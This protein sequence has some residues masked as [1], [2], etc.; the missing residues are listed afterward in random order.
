M[1]GKEKAGVEATVQTSGPRTQIERTKEAREKLI[2]AAFVCFGRSGYTTTTLSDI[3]AEA[4]VSRE[5][6]RYH[7]GSRD[8]LAVVLHERVA[9]YWLTKFSAT[10]DAPMSLP[11]ALQRIG[12]M[13]RE[14]FVF[15]RGGASL[16]V[17]SAKPENAQL[18]DALMRANT[19]IFD[20]MS[21]I[22]EVELAA[23]GRAGLDGGA[24]TTIIF[25]TFRGLILRTS[26]DMPGNDMLKA[27]AAFEDIILTTIRR[28]K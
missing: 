14:D 18:R 27:W 21:E 20:R 25:A 15:L 2:A 23:H 3:A 16:Q 10:A 5:L 17:E 22:V 4:G 11:V 6:P 13:L 12:E 28:S 1:R 24:L 19:A 7:F 9:D 26:M 8:E